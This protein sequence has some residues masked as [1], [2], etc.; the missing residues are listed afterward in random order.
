MKYF[1]GVDISLTHLGCVVL[2]SSGNLITSKIIKTKK[3][4]VPIE[5][6]LEKRILYIR[7]NLNFIRE[8][9]DAFLATEEVLWTARGQGS[10]QLAA[11]EI[12][13]RSMFLEWNI[14]F[15]TVFPATLKKQIA[16]N[17]HASKED[18]INTVSVKYNF[19]TKDDNLADAYALAIYA[20]MLSHSNPS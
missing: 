11:V 8:F 17:G 1:I 15:Q 3:S 10:V 7:D 14:E 6:E 5:H 4:K 2:D 19:V 13:L 12:F 20:K 18:M 16:G 9:K